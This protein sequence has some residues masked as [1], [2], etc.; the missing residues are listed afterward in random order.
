MLQY[1]LAVDNAILSLRYLAQHFAVLG[2]LLMVVIKQ[3]TN[4][5]V[6]TDENNIGHI[7]PEKY[8]NLVWCH[9]STVTSR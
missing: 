4:I 6:G 8:A 3:S 5:S 7:V 1:F 2:V 9:V